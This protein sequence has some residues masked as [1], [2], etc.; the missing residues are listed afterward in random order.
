MNFNPLPFTVVDWS[1]MPVTTFSGSSGTGSE[2]ILNMGDLRVRVV[3]FSAG[4]FADH[5]CDRGH[6]LFVLEGE[7]VSQLKDGRRFV[8]KKGMS[9]QV[10]NS[11]D[12]PHRTFTPRA[13]RVFI[14]D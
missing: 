7:L 8:L 11:G 1:A 10:S 13:A 14:V 5:W 3:D 12:Q 9:Y 2:R 6:V 4:Y